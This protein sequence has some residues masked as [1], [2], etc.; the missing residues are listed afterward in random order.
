MILYKY[1]IDSNLIH[2]L[3]Y[4]DF[5]KSTKEAYRIEEVGNHCIRVTATSRM[6]PIC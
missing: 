1:I 3:Y 4:R 2:L 6:V 5:L